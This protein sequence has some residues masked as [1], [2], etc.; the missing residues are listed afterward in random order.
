MAHCVVVVMYRFPSAEYVRTSLAAGRL[1]NDD[2][3]AVRAG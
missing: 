2:M 1:G 3:C